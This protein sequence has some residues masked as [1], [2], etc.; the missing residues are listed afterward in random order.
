MEFSHKPVL[1]GETIEVLRINPCGIYVDGTAGGG[2]HSEQIAN[3]LT[4]G[5]LICIDVYKR[6][7]HS[8]AADSSQVPVDYTEIRRVHKPSGA[9]PGFVI[10]EGQSTVY[11]TPDKMLADKLRVK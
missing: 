7:L 4:S 9:K 3:R 6:Q 8:R 11:V 5:R 10:Y 2:G 1:L